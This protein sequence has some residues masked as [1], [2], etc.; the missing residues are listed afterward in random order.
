MNNFGNEGTPAEQEDDVMK[1]VK[2]ASAKRWF[3]GERKDR[4]QEL[5]EEDK[6]REFK[7]L[8]D[9]ADSEYIQAHDEAAEKHGN[10]AYTRS[11]EEIKAHVKELGLEESLPDHLKSLGQTELEV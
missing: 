7:R 5:G 2:I 9:A 8:E 1:R 4:A 10:L 6:A 3:Y 11:P